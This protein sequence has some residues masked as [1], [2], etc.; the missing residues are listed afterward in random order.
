MNLRSF[1]LK[2]YG[3]FFLISGIISCNQ[4]D[5]IIR[6]S[7]VVNI[8]LYVYKNDTIQIFYSEKTDDAYTE[9]LSIKKYVEGKNKMQT[10]R[11]ELPI[12]VKPKNLRIDLG[13]QPNYHDSI[14]IES[15]SFK[16]RDLILDG[17]NGAYK[18]WFIPNENIYFDKDTLIYKFRVQGDIY[19]P[20]LNGNKTL[21]SK[22]VKLFRPD[23]YE[24]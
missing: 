24:R 14:R 13:E 23:I 6:E 15:V 5:K 9:E 4:S 19:D 10:L 7:L 1:F 17:K 18:K 21:N 20:Q 2:S 22:L 16:Y 12:G 11:Y 3:L 8:E